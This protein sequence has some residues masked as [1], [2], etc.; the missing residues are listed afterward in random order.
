[1]S[2]STWFGGLQKLTFC[3]EADYKAKILTTAL[4]IKKLYCLT[5]PSKLAGRQFHNG[6][7][8]ATHVE[9][10]PSNAL[11]SA[12]KPST[13]RKLPSLKMQKTMVVAAVSSRVAHAM[14]ARNPWT[15]HGNHFCFLCVDNRAGKRTEK[16]HKADLTATQ[17]TETR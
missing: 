16:Q 10:H 17:K 6:L 13:I 3:L 9:H 7:R 5:V 8:S 2:R 14:R 11:S 15:C 12:P 1:M 4:W